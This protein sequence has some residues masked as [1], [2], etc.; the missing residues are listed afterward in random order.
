[1]MK[2]GEKRILWV[3][4]EIEHL[5]SH[6][7]ILQERGYDVLTASNGHDALSLLKGKPIDLILLDQM[8]PGMDGI[9]T[10]AELRRVDPNIP[11]V[12]VTKSEEETLMDEAFGKDV[13]D[14][15]VKPINPRQLISLCKRILEKRDMIERRMPQDYASEFNR[16]T[17]LRREGPDW[18][19][20]TDIYLALSEW[21]IW[22]DR[23][24]EE[25]LASTHVDQKKDC[26]SEF[27][28]FISS[29]YTDW[30]SSRNRPTMSPDIFREYVFPKMLKNRKVVF[31]L[32]DCMKLDQYL[33]LEPLLKERFKVRRDFYCSIL[34]SATPYARNAIF[35]GLFPLEMSKQNPELWGVREEG[36]QNKYEREFGEIALKRD[37]G[38]RFS[39]EYVKVLTAA[40]A[41]AL[42]SNLPRLL[43][44]QL[45][46]IVVNFVD[47]LTHY[48]S[49]STV[50]MEMTADE[51]ALRSFAHTWFARSPILDVINQVSKED[52]DIILT[53]DHGSIQTGRPCTIYGGREISSN[54]RYKFGNSIRCDEKQALLIRQPEEYMLPTDNPNKRYCIAKED[55]Y[56]VYPTHYQRYV[57]QYRGTFQHGGVSMDEMILPVATLTAQ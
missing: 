41:E 8:M 45:L 37:T 16:I 6:I 40:D 3:D 56:F 5:R 53:S 20:W 24:K 43:E 23:F 55:Y 22:I 54:L 50:V 14:F 35:S 48:R 19:V 34:P 42:R 30:V 47:I 44:N 51:D 9:T 33:A 57:K 15:L 2:K 18:N 29:Q 26:N 21:D 38:R 32:L 27:S 28:K 4:D 25:S 12:M 1:M 49:E 11:I 7:Y 39:F 13:A 17:R 10:L 31:V 52:A 36:S 46:A